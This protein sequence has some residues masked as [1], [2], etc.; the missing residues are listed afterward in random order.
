MPEQR[1]HRILVHGD[2]SSNHGRKVLDDTATQRPATHGAIARG[3]FNRAL[4]SLLLCRLQQHRPDLRD[5]QAAP[6]C[7]RAIPRYRSR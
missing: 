2:E 5:D 4:S 6:G 3:W 7:S 1:S